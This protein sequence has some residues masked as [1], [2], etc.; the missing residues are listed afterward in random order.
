[1]EDSLDLSQDI[2]RNGRTTSTAA[3]ATASTTFTTDAANLLS[4]PLSDRNFVLFEWSRDFSV[5]TLC[6]TL[7]NRGIVVRYPTGVKY[8]ACSNR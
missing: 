6:Y 5:G 4:V 2:L 7:D 3:A 8:L 1:M